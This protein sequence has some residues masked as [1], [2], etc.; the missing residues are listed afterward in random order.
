MASENARGGQNPLRSF[1]DKY[2]FSDAH[3][4]KITSCDFSSNGDLAMSASEDM[5][6]KLWRTA[7]GVLLK[8]LVGHYGE[9]RRCS[10]SPC[11]QKILSAGDQTLRLW[12]VLTGKLDRI[13]QHSSNFVC[14]SFSSD[15]KSILGG[16]Q[17][18]NVH[19][20]AVA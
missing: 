13:V 6:I 2:E 15:G 7:T 20:W 18:G 8:I 3:T 16:C 1:K 19:L 10:F 14:C 4:A 9:V 5:T 11:G 17:N 12:S